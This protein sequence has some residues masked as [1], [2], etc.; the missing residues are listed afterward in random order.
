MGGMKD[1]FGDQPFRGFEQNLPTP[2]PETLARRTDPATSHEAA[3]AIA[4]KIGKLQQEVL[5]WAKEDPQSFYGF[6]DRQLCAAMFARHPGTRESTWRT[7]RSELRDL[8]LIVSFDH[9][10]IGGKRHIVW[11]VKG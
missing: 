5:D 10:L 4:P 6:T 11:R 9:K 8:G 1:L 2:R 7:R 3:A